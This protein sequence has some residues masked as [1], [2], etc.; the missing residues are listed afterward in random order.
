MA[1]TNENDEEYD[2]FLTAD[3]GGGGFIFDSDSLAVV[4]GTSRATGGR[5][6]HS[7]Q[8]GASSRASR[9]AATTQLASDVGSVIGAKKNPFLKSITFFDPKVYY[10]KTGVTSAAADQTKK[11]GEE[12]P[13]GDEI[14]GKSSTLNDNGI[15]QQTTDN[16]DNDSEENNINSHDGDDIMT[17]EINDLTHWEILLTDPPI[18]E[19]ISYKK[20]KSKMLGKL[21]S[22]KVVKSKKVKR[23]QLIIGDFEGLVEFSSVQS[24]DRLVSINKKKIKPE[25]Y[26]AVEAMVY[27][28]ECIVNDGVLHVTT[29][30]PQGEF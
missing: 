10:R 9:S 14:G 23:P 8:Y 24:G 4:R 5:H 2:S 1:A 16:D 20:K 6:S 27:M 7:P 30:N 11:D 26:S 13:T 19:M 17:F 28:R 29:E 21:L 15:D 25:E 12:D 3:G 18:Q 22:N